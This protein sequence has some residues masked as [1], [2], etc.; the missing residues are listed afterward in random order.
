MEN[1]KHYWDNNVIATH[2]ILKHYANTRVLFA[3]SSSQYEPWLN[4]Y[5]ASKNVIEAIP[6]SNRVAMRFHTVYGETNRQGMFFDKLKKEFDVERSFL[7]NDGNVT[8]LLSDFTKIYWFKF[9]E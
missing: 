8:K 7:E 6:H 2:K 3:S 4:P 1:P 9:R 5:A